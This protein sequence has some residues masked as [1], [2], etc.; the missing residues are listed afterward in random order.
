MLKA[1]EEEQLEGRLHTKDEALE[2]IKARF[3][4]AGREG[5]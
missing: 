2:W 4:V 1:L 5:G 3:P